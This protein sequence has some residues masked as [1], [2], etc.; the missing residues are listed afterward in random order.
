MNA[1]LLSLSSNYLISKTKK[2]FEK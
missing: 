2:A 1:I